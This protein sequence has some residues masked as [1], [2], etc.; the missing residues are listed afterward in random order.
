[1]ANIKLYAEEAKIVHESTGI[2]VSLR[3]VNLGDVVSEF[4]ENDVL[5]HIDFDTVMDYVTKRLEE[6]DE[7]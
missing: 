5:D 3:G 6:D 1:M 7:T 2:Y 4:S